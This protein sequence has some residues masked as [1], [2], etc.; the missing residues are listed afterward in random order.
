M[1]DLRG[2]FA[3]NR[4]REAQAAVG[5]LPYAIADADIREGTAAVVATNEAYTL[6]TLPDN[7]LV[8]SV[9]LIVETGGEFVAGTATV[10][11]GATTVI[12][13]LTDL[14]TAGITSSDDCPI[15][16]EGSADVVITPASL[17]VDAGNALA[18][19]KVVIGYVDFDRATMSYIG[20]E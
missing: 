6:L 19:V 13:A 1:A 16:V 11:I 12:P 4:R 7:I 15:I 2:L 5:T 17:T 20:E 10:T 3:N 14:T 18:K 9:D 8:T